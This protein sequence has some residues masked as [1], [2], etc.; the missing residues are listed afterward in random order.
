[1]LKMKIFMR[2][3]ITTGLFSSLAL[4]SV[5]DAPGP[6]V[7]I[8][9]L[10]DSSVRINFVDNSDNE[11]GFKLFTDGREISVPANDES[12]HQHVYANLT[13]LTCDKSYTVYA[14]AYNGDGASAQTDSRGFNINTTFS[15]GCTHQN[16]A[17]EANAS[18]DQIVAESDVVQLDGSN[19]HD[20]DGDTLTYKWVITNKPGGSSATLSD[21]T[22]INP[23]F[24]ADVIGIYTISLVVNDGTEDSTV[25]TVVVNATITY[26]HELNVCNQ[27]SASNSGGIAG[28]YDRWDISQIPDGATFDFKFEAY[29]IPDKFQVDY[30]GVT[31]LKTGW[32]GNRTPTT[33]EA[34]EGPGRFDKNNLFTKESSSNTMSVLVTGA[35][36]GTG[37]YYKVRCIEHNGQ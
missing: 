14:V 20:V 28:T 32:R 11:V 13:G 3:L 9:K 1:M 34:L 5:P 16:T 6:Y 10:T 15:P 19:S 12:V 27:W 29:S 21:D 17:P 37:W 2:L 26:D 31:R 23:T 18:T 33:G 25:D 4:A 8:T 22:A 36:P 35:Q 24:V 30:N 7:G